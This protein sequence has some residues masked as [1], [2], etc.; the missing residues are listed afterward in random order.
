MFDSALSLM[1]SRLTNGSDSDGKNLAEAVAVV[2]N[3]NGCW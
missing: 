3:G 1:T 2:Q